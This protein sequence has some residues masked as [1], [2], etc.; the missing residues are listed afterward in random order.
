MSNFFL[1]HFPQ[2]IPD[3]QPTDN[4][5]Q[6]Y[7]V[8]EHVSHKID[9]KDN[10]GYFLFGSCRYTAWIPKMA[11]FALRNSISAVFLYASLSVGIILSLLILYGQVDTTWSWTGYFLVWP[12]LLVIY[13]LMNCELLRRLVFH[14]FLAF[15]QNLNIAIL[16]AGLFL[17][18]MEDKRHILTVLTI[19]GFIA[20]YIDAL[21][22]GIRYRFVLVGVPVGLVTVIF[23]ISVP[24]L[25]GA[26]YQNMDLL[27]LGGVKLSAKDLVTS[28]GS[29]VAILCIRYI[30]SA[31]RHKSALVLVNEKVHSVLVSAVEEQVILR[32]NADKQRLKNMPELG[33]RFISAILGVN[34][35]IPWEMVKQGP[36]EEGNWKMYSRPNGGAG[37][38]LSE[39]KICF[40]IATD[41]KSVFAHK[42]DLNSLDSNIFATQ[43][44]DPLAEDRYL[45]VLAK[46]SAIKTRIFA[47]HNWGKVI[48]EDL[49]LTIGVS[50]EHALSLLEKSKLTK[51]HRAVIGHVHMGGYA[52]ERINDHACRVTYLVCVDMKG[53]IP[54]IVT[55][56]ISY[57]KAKK[58]ARKLV[59]KFGPYIAP[60]HTKKEND[61]EDCRSPALSQIG[62]SIAL[63]SN[64]H[65]KSQVLPNQNTPNYTKRRVSSKYAVTPL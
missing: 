4:T 46:H 64:V 49:A 32:E 5:T 53:F 21:P 30:I 37:S 57:S 17:G 23:L 6:R 27:E 36:A 11:Y 10:L 59:E 35:S 31:L 15:Y 22:G 50:D 65:R 34:G 24:F 44:F 38:N 42:W 13:C 29:N 51:K 16:L 58:A 63:T 1:V 25:E 54:Y 61:L 62:S 20:A 26:Q 48:D 3:R 12:P 2:G 40:D 52:F 43:N 56:N 45:W 9:T 60:A 28:A 19:F 55:N 18:S 7:L 8:T 14:N 33:K 41:I 39:V 47:W